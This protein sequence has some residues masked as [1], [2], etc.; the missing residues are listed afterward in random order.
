MTQN[1]CRIT[2]IWLDTGSMGSK[3]CK[4]SPKRSLLGLFN[5]V[6]ECDLRI[7]DE[8]SKSDKPDLDSLGWK[9]WNQKS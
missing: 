5:W 3:L 9:S 6:W 1:I 2:S 8:P 4:V 7:L